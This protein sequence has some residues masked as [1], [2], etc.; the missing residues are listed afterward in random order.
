[1]SRPGVCRAGR[2]S[3]AVGSEALGDPRRAVPAV[4]C[5]ESESVQEK[6]PEMG[7]AVLVPPVWRPVVVCVVHRARVLVIEVELE[8][9]L[10]PSSTLA[11]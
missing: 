7:D 8:W 2:T 3:G 4:L 11:R 1:M 5:R 10:R 6:C 9:Q